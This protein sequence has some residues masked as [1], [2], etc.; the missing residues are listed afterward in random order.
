MRL[1]AP[2]NRLAEGVVRIL[3][4][5]LLRNPDQLQRLRDHPELLDSAVDELLRFDSPVQLNGRSALQDVQL[6]GKRIR[7]GD[8]VISLI[9]AAN[10][11]PEVFNDP[12]S[13]D[14]GRQEKSHLSFSR[15]IHYC[16]GAPLALAEARI[17]FATVLKRFS[18][19]RLALEPQY[20]KGVVLRRAALAESRYS[21]PSCSRYRFCWRP[22][23]WQ[24]THKEP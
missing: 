16:F 3:V 2:P 13:L 21:N 15:G 10:R 1:P 9:G 12:E 19:I 23:L 14:I 7:A 5:A 8:V 20:L 11:D 17:A 22:L 6:G 18:S 24:R 4:L